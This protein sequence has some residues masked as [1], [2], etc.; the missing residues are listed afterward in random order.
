MTKRSTSHFSW[1]HLLSGCFPWCAGCTRAG[2]ESQLAEYRALH[3]TPFAASA[4]ISELDSYRA[5]F[6]DFDPI[7]GRM[8]A[9]AGTH[10]PP[11]IRSLDAQEVHIYF[12]WFHTLIGAETDKQYNYAVRNSGPELQVELVSA[13]ERMTQYIGNGF[14][15]AVFTVGYRSAAFIGTYHSV[16]KLL[17]NPG[18]ALLLEALNMGRFTH[19][20]WRELKLN[21][22]LEDL[23]KQG[24]TPTETVQERE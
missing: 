18:I 19:E 4:A 13:T 15:F 3:E 16:H 6:P 14:T 24:E 20:E 17:T 5:A 12:G 21:A 22:L 9:R 23:R 1:Y 10:V 11:N 7:V 2:G 8:D